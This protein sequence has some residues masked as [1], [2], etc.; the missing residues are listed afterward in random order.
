MIPI[1]DVPLM[2]RDHAGL[3]RMLAG[4]HEKPDAELLDSFD[5]IASEL[6]EHFAREEHAMTEA[7][8]PILDCH[9]ELHAQ[10]LREVDVM[11]AEIVAHGPAS[12]RD[13]VGAVLPQMIANH[14]AAADTVSA[15]F[16]RDEASARS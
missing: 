15:S 2:D 16:L 7:R 14:I 12:A 11:R 1:L 4:F 6:R 3:E 8:V 13:L 9:L 10:I 5:A